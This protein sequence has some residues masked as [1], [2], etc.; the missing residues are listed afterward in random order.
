MRRRHGFTLRSDKFEDSDQVVSDQVEH[1]IGADAGEPV[2]LGRRN[3][4]C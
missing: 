3:V 1:E 2:V 4:P